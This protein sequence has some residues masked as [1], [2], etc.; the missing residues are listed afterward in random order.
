MP[1]R[2]TSNNPGLVAPP[3]GFWNKPGLMASPRGNGNNQGLVDGNAP[4]TSILE[5]ATAAAT[6]SFYNI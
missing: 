5:P 6:K 1:P 4:Y 3:W 2:R